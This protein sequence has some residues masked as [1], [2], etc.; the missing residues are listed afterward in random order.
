MSMKEACAQIEADARQKV[1]HQVFGHLFPKEDETFA[2]TARICQDVYGNTVILDD[3]SN[4]PNSPWWYETL[5][6]WAFDFLLDH[7]DTGVVFEH[8]IMVHVSKHLY[9]EKIEE[10][11]YLKLNITSTGYKTVL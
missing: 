10:T 7:K 3:S 1:Q 5:N 8:E 6:E 9:E 11:Y 2:G 4:V